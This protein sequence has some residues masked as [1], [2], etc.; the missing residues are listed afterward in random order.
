VKDSAAVPIAKIA[1]SIALCFTLAFGAGAAPRLSFSDSWQM[2]GTYNWLYGSY[3]IETAGSFSATMTVPVNGFDLS[4]LGYY[5][6]VSFNI[7]P[8]GQMSGVI[9]QEILGR[10]DYTPGQNFAIYSFLS[11]IEDPVSGQFEDYG[12]VKV[13]WTNDTISVTANVWG[14]CLGESGLF[15]SYSTGKPTNFA[16]TGF[17][18]VSLTLD[19]SLNGGGVFTYDNTYVSVKGYNKE[20]EDNIPGGGS[21]PLEAGCITGTADFTPPKLSI[22][23]PASGFMAYDTNPII[24]LE[25]TASDSSF[26]TNVEC[27]VNGDTNNLISIDQDSLLPA[28]SLAWTADVDMSATGHPGTNIVTVIA[29]NGDGARTAVSRTYYW[30]ETNIAAVSVSPPNAG[31]ITGIRNGQILR[32]GRGYPVSAAPAG[33]DWIFSGWTDGSGHVLSSSARFD[34][35]DENVTLTN[36]APPA[37]TAVFVPNPFANASLAGAYTGLY[38]DTTN[39]TQVFDDGYL[40]LS[41]TKTG[42]FSGRLYNASRFAFAYPFS[43]QL[44]ES[45][46]GS[47]A[48]A[49]LPLMKLSGQTCLQLTLRI[50]TDAEAGLLSGV[51]TSFSDAFG[52]NFIGTAEIQGEATHYNTNILPGHYNFVIAPPSA[53]PNNGPGGYSFGTATVSKSGSVTM[54]LRLAEGSLPEITVGSALARDGACP[55]YASLVGGGGVILGWLRF[56]TNGSGA[57]NTTAAYW[58]EV[59]GSP[60]NYYYGFAALPALSG[61]LY[62]AP[63]PGANILTTT[64]PIVQ[65]A[66]G[67]TAPDVAEMNVPVLF[68]TKNSTFSI[69]NNVNKL[70]VNLNP[71]TGAFSGAVYGLLFQ[72]FDTYQGLIVNGTGYGYWTDA[73]GAIVSMIIAAPAGP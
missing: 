46:D 23:S 61:G 58:V 10:A 60:D 26:I 63:K 28:A 18:E 41:V 53:D 42:A 15:E 5:T 59:P 49:E 72:K 73:Y 48:E 21:T 45:A 54:S 66:P 33:N 3:G 47:Y 50:A 4:Q 69:P 55:F 14:D 52:T 29:Q 20:T 25:G 34:F 65:F 11:G 12:T 67:N 22:A 7:G 37:L 56:A 70:S 30:V 51:V 2:L 43:G 68:N 32:V 13:V 39:N 8:A 36:S 1:A 16:I 6:A 9:D 57:M 62:L 40:M 38:F 24:A 44:S 27:F 71:A 19:N 31:K 35:L 64:A 17:Y